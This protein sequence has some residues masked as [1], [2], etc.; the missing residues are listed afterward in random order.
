MGLLKSGLIARGK[1][2]VIDRP[3]VASVSLKFAAVRWA[4]REDTDDTEII[5]PVTCNF[6]I[7]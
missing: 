2:N 3:I 7:C 1:K 6:L 4:R 5:G